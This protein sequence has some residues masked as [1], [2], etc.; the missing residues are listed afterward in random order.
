MPRPPSVGRPDAAESSPGDRAAGAASGAA[1][2]VGLQAVGLV[3]AGLY[4]VIRALFPDATHRGSTEV[5]GV[6]SLL[7]GMGVGL[8]ARAVWRRQRRAVLNVLE[9]ICLP[10]GVTIIQGGRWYVGAPLIVVALGVLVLLHRAGLMLP[11][12]EEDPD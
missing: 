9:I 3:A 12:R 10:I 11:E 6:L 5:L 8:T 7:V 4:L 2:L 1:A